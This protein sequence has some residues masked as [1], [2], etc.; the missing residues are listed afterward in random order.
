M[1]EDSE[2]AFELIGR[3]G[4]VCVVD[5]VLYLHRVRP[6]SITR[7]FSLQNTSD[8]LLASEYVESYMRE[9][10]PEV[11]SQ[12]DVLRR[13]R[14]RL[15]SEIAYYV[16]SGALRGAEREAARELLGRR[17]ARDCQVVEPRGLRMRVA[18]WMFRRCPWLLSVAYPVHRPLRQLTRMVTGR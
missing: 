8:W 9:R 14:S 18:L 10:V 4:R 12:E 16:R 7:T 5:D 2:A 15:A 6:G 13:V 17:I 11:F 3:C 1:Y